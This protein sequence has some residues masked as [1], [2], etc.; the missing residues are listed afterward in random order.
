M[1]QLIKNT[2]ESHLYTSEKLTMIRMWD[3]QGVD[4]KRNPEVILSEIKNLV[5]N[6]LKNGPDSYINI[7][8][9]CTNVTGNRFQEE[10]G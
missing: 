1:N 7:I 4:Y 9:Y 2:S 3:T 6:G 5:N 10:E 8:L